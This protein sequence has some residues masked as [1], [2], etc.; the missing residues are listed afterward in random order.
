MKNYTLL[1]INS[2]LT[3]LA[4]SSYYLTILWIMYSIT[5]SPFLAGLAD[6]ISAAPLLL[7]FIVGALV[8]RNKK[9][10]LLAIQS[11]LLRVIFLCFIFFSL[12]YNNYIIIISTI[13][14]STF[15]IGLS[16]NIM[17][18]LRV[19]WLKVFL[20]EDKYKSGSSTISAIGSLAQISGYILAGFFLLTRFSISIFVL[21]FFYL[22]SIMPLLFISY[23]EISDD[24]TKANLKDIVFAGWNY[25]KKSESTKELIILDICVGLIFGEIGILLTVLT[26]T[27]LDLSPTFLGFF[28]VSMAAG[29]AFGALLIK[30]IH[31][32]F[33]YTFTLFTMIGAISIA[34]L[35]FSISISSTLILIFA[36]GISEGATN[37]LT[38]F[39]YI[40][41]IPK[42]MTTRIQ[43]IF[44]TFILGI[45]A[46]SGIVAGFLIED[47][48][49]VDTLYV[50]S[51]FLVI[52]IILA[53]R[54]KELKLIKG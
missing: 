42:E 13:Y 40:K 1:I 31:L 34:A 23:S 14:L 16:S 41:I 36:V 28:F 21:I 22:I 54:F 9:K 44:D 49:L 35:G 38:F 51:F 37:V 33:M 4:T 20:N 53:T 43:G 29:T 45:T 8:Y 50:E 39:T 32:N 48:G 15:F 17:S 7:G 6:G 2:F 25:I 46:F 30:K 5:K 18:S 10:K 26:K 52:T 19:L 27:T 3:R 47:V 12:L 24:R 11:S